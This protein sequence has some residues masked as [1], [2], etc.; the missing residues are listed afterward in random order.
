MERAHDRRPLPHLPHPRPPL[1][2]SR[3]SCR[4]GGLGPSSTLRVRFREAEPGTWYYRC[5]VEWLMRNWM[6]GLYRVSR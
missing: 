2:A 4:F 3:R 6:I 5:H 1:A